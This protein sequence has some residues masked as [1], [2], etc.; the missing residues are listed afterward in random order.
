MDGGVKSHINCSLI[1]EDGVGD[2]RRNGIDGDGKIGGLRWNQLIE[3]DFV[4]KTKNMGVGGGDGSVAIFARSGGMPFT[5]GS[6]L[7]Q[8]E[9]GRGE[10]QEKWEAEQQCLEGRGAPH[11]GVGVGAGR[12]GWSGRWQCRV[13]EISW[14]L[15]KSRG[16]TLKFVAGWVKNL[17]LFPVGRVL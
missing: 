1:H 9:G 12:E 13:F 17:V 14:F 6:L 11:V 7:C 2:G 8:R 10:D 3:M 4:F 15:S 5:T 16:F